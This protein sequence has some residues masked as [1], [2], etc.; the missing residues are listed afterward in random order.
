MDGHDE[1]RRRPGGLDTE[2]DLVGTE[3]T[4]GITATLHGDYVLLDSM[5]Y[6][7]HMTIG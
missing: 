2:P 1:R 7:D 4:A 5:A 6:L 3:T